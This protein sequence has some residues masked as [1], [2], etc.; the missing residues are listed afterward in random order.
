MS[1]RDACTVNVAE[2]LQSL[3]NPGE[4]FVRLTRYDMIAA[5]S[6]APGAAVWNIDQL[7]LR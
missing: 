2:S 6:K 3:S 7:T 5:D 4:A 1:E